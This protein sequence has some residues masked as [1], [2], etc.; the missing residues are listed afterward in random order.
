MSNKDN[1]NY[2]AYHI[3]EVLE[4]RFPGDTHYI[5]DKINTLADHNSKA[6]S[7]MWAI[8][9]L[10]ATSETALCEKLN[11]DSRLLPAFAAVMSK[12]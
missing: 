2:V 4:Q 12:L 9:Q 6:E 1:L 3:I 7:L 8:N 5:Q 11:I 10:D